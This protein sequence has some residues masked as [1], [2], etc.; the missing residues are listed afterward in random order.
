FLGA[1]HALHVVARLATMAEGRDLQRSVGSGD[2][3]WSAES[4]RSGRG[5]W[6]NHEGLHPTGDD[7]AQFEPTVYLYDNYPGG[8]GLSEPLFRRAD[9]LVSESLAL[10]RHCA[11]AHGCPACV[12]PTLIAPD[13][14]VRSPKQLAAKVLEL[15]AA[16]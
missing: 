5:R 4:D 16:S 10:I 3:A 15:L 1:A 14:P 12:G 2:G 6:R 8:I 13:D 11:C 7:A 9:G